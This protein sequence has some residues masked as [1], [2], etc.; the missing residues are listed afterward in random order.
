MH[1]VAWW[2][3][4][5]EKTGLIEVQC[6]EL[7]AESDDLLRDYAMERLPEQDE[8]SI[9]RAVPHDQDGLIALFCLVA[10]KR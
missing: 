2:K 1:T 4:H 6:A 10:C 9:M 3:Q 5:W 7:L 8:D